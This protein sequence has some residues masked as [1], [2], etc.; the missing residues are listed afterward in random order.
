M[1]SMQAGQALGSWFP[2]LLSLNRFIPDVDVKPLRFSQLDYLKTLCASSEVCVCAYSKADGRLARLITVKQI[3]YA[4]L[5]DYGI[6]ISIAS[7]LNSAAA[8]LPHKIWRKDPLWRSM[9]PSMW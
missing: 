4:S 1:Y 3:T 5:L 8:K 9:P 2:F 6:Q 7:V